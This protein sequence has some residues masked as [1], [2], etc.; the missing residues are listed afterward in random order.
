MTTK[1]LSCVALILFVAANV[2]AQT[3]SGDRIAL[4]YAHLKNAEAMASGGLIEANDSLLAAAKKLTPVELKKACIESLDRTTK[5]IA[6]APQRRK[7]ET[8][9]YLKDAMLRLTVDREEPH[10]GHVTWAQ[11]NPGKVTRMIRE[12][13]Q[14]LKE[15][16]NKL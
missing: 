14:T 6:S 11:Q 16:L 1:L 8:M 3:V 2:V 4:V 10:T 9:A 13:S 15:A 5:V 12:Y 7:P